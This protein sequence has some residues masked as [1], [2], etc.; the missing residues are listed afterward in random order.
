MVKSVEGIYRNGKIELLEPIEG[1]EGNLVIVSWIERTA[2]VDLR[3]KGI[4]EDQAAD[5]RHRLSRFNEDWDRP[6]MD[7]YDNLLPR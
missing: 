1:A 4:A 3:Q 2:T 6:E 5:L 7:V